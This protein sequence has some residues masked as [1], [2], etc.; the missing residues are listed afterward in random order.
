MLK[1]KV[2]A[3]NSYPIPDKN[4]DAWMVRVLRPEVIGTFNGKVI[5]ADKMNNPKYWRE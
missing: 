3:V 2:L 5:C 4:A 1:N